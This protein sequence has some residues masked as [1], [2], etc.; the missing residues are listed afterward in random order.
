MAQKN[1]RHETIIRLVESHMVT[2]QTDLL[3][4]L[5]E[6]GFRITQ[7]TLSRDIKQLKLVKLPGESGD[8]I[9]R[10]AL[11]KQKPE[12]SPSG[13]PEEGIQGVLSVEFSRNLAVLK[14]RPGY[15]MAIASE[16]D[17]KIAGRI[18]GTI[19]GD[20]TILL[21][22]H[23]GASRKLVLRDLRR[24]LPGITYTTSESE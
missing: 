4:L 14:T 18:M 22:L 8:Y 10:V 20:D 12:E 1:R 11:Q 6:E 17:N 24:I 21:I 13:R 23:E 3:A 15:A 7:A 19:A 5:K 2:N 16:I 9:W